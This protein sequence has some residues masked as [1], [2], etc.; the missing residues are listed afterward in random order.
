[1]SPPET[2]TVMDDD[3]I[4]AQDENKIINEVSCATPRTWLVAKMEL[5]SAGV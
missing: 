4:S 2:V 3:E 1:M 5:I